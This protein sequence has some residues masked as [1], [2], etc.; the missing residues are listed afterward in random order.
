MHRIIYESGKID[1]VVLLIDVYKDYV[2]TRKDKLKNSQIAL[3][4][5]DK[6]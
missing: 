3:K 2:P 1:R 4:F 6:G 5:V